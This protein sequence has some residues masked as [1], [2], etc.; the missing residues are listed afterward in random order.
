M[1]E[2]SGSDLK[3]IINYVKEKRGM[4]GVKGIL[5]ELNSGSV[6]ISSVGDIG[7]TQAYNEDIYKKVI[8]AAAKALGGDLQTRFTQIG[9][10]LGDRAKMTKFVAKLSTSKQL[11]R[12]LEDRIITDI[13]Y[14]KSSVQE[15]SKHIVILRVT[16]RKEGENFLYVADGYINAVLDQANKSLTLSDKKLTKDELVYKFTLGEKDEE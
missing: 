4:V 11:L 12:I 1:Q 7:S 16:P 14:V 15:I 6:L 3:F 8:E 13:P 5:K 10:A 2:A 9:Y